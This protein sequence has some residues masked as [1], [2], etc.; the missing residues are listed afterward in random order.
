MAGDYETVAGLVI[1]H[2]RRLPALGDAFTLNCWRFE[3][4]DL[5]YRRIDKLLV[6]RE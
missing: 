3:V 2:L 4:I 5:D 6:A 1:N